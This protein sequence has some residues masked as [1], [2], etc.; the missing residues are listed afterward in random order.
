MDLVEMVERTIGARKDKLILILQGLTAAGVLLSITLMVHVGPVTLF[1]FMTLAQGLIVVSVIGTSILLIT[2]RTGITRERYG[3]GEVIL[4]K[5]EVGEK[6]YIVEHGE[7][8]A[9]DEEPGG[10][11]KIIATLGAGEGFGEVALVTGQPYLG[12]V[13]SRTE[14]TLITVDRQSFQALLHHA[15]L[16]RMVEGIIEE[17]TKR[18]KEIR[19]RDS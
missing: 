5:G 13:R 8:D 12:T 17:R 11:E 14:V 19:E 9:I 18:L 10:G 15:P 4:R 16:R 2:Q 7:V 1:T 3:P 6:V